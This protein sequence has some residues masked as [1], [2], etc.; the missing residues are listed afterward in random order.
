MPAVGQGRIAIGEGSSLW[1]LEAVRDEGG[2]DFHAHHA[3]Q[4]TFSLEGGFEIG[5]PDVSLSGPAVAVA[6]D[7]RHVFHAH[8]MVAFLFVEPESE[9]G[10]AISASVLAGRDIAAIEAVSVA[11]LLEALRTVFRDRSA[12]DRD[13]LL[14]ADEIVARIAGSRE[15]AAPDPR[16]RKMIAFAR[17]RLDDALTL[18]EAADSV[19]LSEGRARHLFA[20]QTGLPFKTFLLWLRIR[21]AVELYAAGASLTEAAHEAGFADSAH[22]S[23]TF[24]RHFGIPAAALRINARF[25]PASSP[26]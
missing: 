1:V 20:D 15:A 25:T 11:P 18:S 21:R 8:G 26:P 16:V 13:L 19:G 23:R 22:F 2:A 10:R 3:I 14:L 6:G 4:L 9:A 7:A 24:R 17:E 5:T 12:D